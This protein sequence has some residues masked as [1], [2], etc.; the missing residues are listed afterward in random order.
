LVKEISAYKYTNLI[1]YLI[2]SE[3]ANVN[4]SLN[5]KIQSVFR[6]ESTIYEELINFRKRL[7]KLRENMR[8]N[9][10]TLMEA[11]VRSF[12]IFENL[13]VRTIDAAFEFVDS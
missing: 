6:S 1:I 2:R 3:H 7:H 10:E 5:H 13:R 4:I 9:L 12:E 8:R 11:R